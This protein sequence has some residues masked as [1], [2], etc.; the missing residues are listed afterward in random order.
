[1]E[2]GVEAVAKNLLQEG[3][4][5]EFVMK[6]TGLGRDKVEEIKKGPP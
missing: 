2:I 6:V 1:M 3:T 4:K 5:I